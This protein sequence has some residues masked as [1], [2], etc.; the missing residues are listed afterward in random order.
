MKEIKRK[1]YSELS[2]SSREKLANTLSRLERRGITITEA[3][4]MS[5]PQLRV[6]LGFKG[7]KAS[8]LGLRRNIQQITFTE[9]HKLGTVNIATTKFIKYG[10]GGKGLKLAKSRLIKTVGKTF[11]SIS[12]EF[13]KEGMK[14]K[15][16]HRRTREILALP[17]SKYSTKLTKKE[18]DILSD[19]GY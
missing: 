15:E 8:L 14:T 18:R 10:Y 1:K 19:Y 13:I 4:K 9:T 2:V 12:G 3:K 7:K 11:D 5:N 16:A 17:K 6:A